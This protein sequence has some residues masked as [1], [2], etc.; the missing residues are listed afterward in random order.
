MLYYMLQ[1][2][3]FQIVFLL[4]YDLF[5]KR[6]TFFNYNRVYLLGT[7]VISCILPFIKLDSIKAVAPKDFVVVLPEVI[8]GNLNPSTELDRQIAL[9]AGIVME[10]PSIPVWQ[11]VLWSGMI[12]TALLFLYKIS[13][14]VF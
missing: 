8:I 9:Q 2:V 13:S 10:E 4:V 6:E 12:L 3:A 1:I 11:I 5:L 14:M 7:A